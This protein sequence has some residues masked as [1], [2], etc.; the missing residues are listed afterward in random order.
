MAINRPDLPLLSGV[1]VLSDRKAKSGAEDPLLSAL[2]DK[3]PTAGT[4]WPAADRQAWLTMMN[5][6]FD[7][8]YGGAGGGSMRSAAPQRPRPAPKKK[9][10]AA[11]RP[12]P[13]KVLRAGPQFFID[14]QNVARR[15]G[16]DRIMPAEVMGILVDK[17]GQN[18]D[19]GTITWAD[20]SCGIPKGV[21]LDIGIQDGD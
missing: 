8:V 3:L 11:R 14:R 10:A 19:L 6:A 5:N 7:V 1:H 2:V 13:A 15:A 12:T 4:S 18:G 16:G 9:P 17:R 21:Q 20:D